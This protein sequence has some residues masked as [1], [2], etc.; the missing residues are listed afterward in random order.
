VFAQL[1]PNDHK[2]LVFST[3][4]EGMRVIT[5]IKAAETAANYQ[6]TSNMR[7]C[8][9]W[10]AAYGASEDETLDELGRRTSEN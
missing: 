4:Q 8:P 5:Q 3:W 1:S 9:S 6:P 2:Y 10:L 7:R